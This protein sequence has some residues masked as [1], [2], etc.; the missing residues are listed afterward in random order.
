MITPKIYPLGDYSQHL[1]LVTQH[2][3]AGVVTLGEVTPRLWY[4]D[5][6]GQD[7]AHYKSEWL[8]T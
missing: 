4:F 8:A 3:A 5:R 2:P 1:A 7:G 6:S